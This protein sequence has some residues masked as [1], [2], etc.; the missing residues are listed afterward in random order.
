[1]PKIVERLHARRLYSAK[2]SSSDSRIIQGMKE[3]NDLLFSSRCPRAYGRVS[4]D[5][6]RVREGN[7]Y[8]S[9]DRR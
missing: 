4:G 7:K 2:I 5:G 6:T 3:E 1:M 9:D 8:V